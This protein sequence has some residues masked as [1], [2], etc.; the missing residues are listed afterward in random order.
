MIRILFCA[1]AALGS[2]ASPTLPDKSRSASP[3]APDISP[4]GKLVA[5]SY[6]GDLWLVDA[7][8]GVAQHLTMHEK[9]DFNPVFSPD[10]KWIAFSSNRHGQ[11]DVFVVPVKGGRPKRLTY[12]SADDHV[13]GWSPDGKH[14]LF[15]RAAARS[16][17]PHRALHRPARRRPGPAHQRLRGPRRRLS[18]PKGDRIAY[19]RGPGTWYRKGYRGS[20]NDDIWICDADGAQQSPHHHA[21]RPGQLPACGR[22]DG[23]SLYYVSDCPR[24]P[25]TSSSRARRRLAPADRQPVA[26]TQHKDDSVRRA[27]IGAQTARRSSTSAA[28]IS[29][30]ISLKEGKSRKLEDRGPRRRQDQPRTAQDLHQRR[31][32]VRLVARREAHRLRRARR[33]LSDAAQRRQG[34]TAHRSS[35]LRSRHRLG[36]RRQE[37]PLPLRPQR[38][39]R[40]L[41][42]RIRTTPT[43]PSSSQAHQLQGQAAHQHARSRVR[44]QLL[45]R[46]QPRRLPPRRQARHHEPR[47]QRREGRSST[48]GRSSITSGRPTASGSATPAWTAPSPAS[49]SS[50]PRPAP[51]AADPPRNVTRFA[52]YNGGVT[53]SKTG[54]KL[55]FISQPPGQRLQRLCPVAAES[56]PRQRLS[57]TSQRT[58]TGTTSICASSSRR[59]MNVNE[60]AISSDGTKIAFRAAVDDSD[61]LWVANADGGQVTR[62]TTGNLKPTQIQWSRSSPARSISAT[63]AATSA[64]PVGG[65]SRHRTARTVA[66]TAKM[67]VRQDD[68]FP[69][70]FDQS[71]RALNE[72]FYDAKF[73]GAD[74][75]DV[76]TS[77]ARS[78]STVRMK[79]DL[80][81]PISLMLGELNASHL[82]ITGN[83]GAPEQQTADLGLIFDRPLPRPGL[84]I[85][86]ILKRRPRRPARP[87]P[88]AGRP[89]PR[90]R[91]HE[92][93]ENV[94]VSQAAQRQGRRDRSSLHV[95]S[96]RRTR[97]QAPRRDSQARSRTQD[98]RAACTN[99]GSTDNADRGQRAEQAASSATSTSRAWT[100]PAWIASSAPST[101][102][103]ST[104]T[105]SS[106]TS[107]TTAAASRTIRC[108][109]TSP[110]RST[111][112]SRHRDGASGP[113][114]AIVRPQMDQA[115]HAA[116]QQSLLS[117][118]PRSSPRL[119]HLGPGQARRPADRR[120]RH[121]HAQ[122]AL[123][124][125]S[126]FRTP[127]I[128][129]HT[130]KGVNME[131]EG[132]I[133]DVLVEPHPDQLARGI[134][135][136]LDRAVEVLDAMTWPRGRKRGRPIA[137]SSAR[138]GRAEP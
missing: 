5:F 24:R 15:I 136:Q 11:Y 40:H 126:T 67:T 59:A 73:H 69:E 85:A 102:T 129:V 28:P 34:E 130:L 42:A 134:D 60:C 75:H 26:V 105:A 96:T 32:R 37:D 125:G 72:N 22:A 36:P 64:P 57:P 47:R 21:Q 138:A 80:Y 87:Q 23:K 65:R 29:G 70:M 122:I 82:G 56:P 117:A 91:R 3:A 111:P 35:R 88:Q 107:A 113:G 55:A 30:S 81:C 92:L 123:I 131:K 76:R 119:P 127:R 137:R 12:D 17:R 14:I 68:L 83:L 45:P 86:E 93:T 8:G 48:T 99:A 133:P 74:W 2:P 124:D 118:T 66:F 77:T 16:S 43:I 61:D 13:T 79:E 78:S 71:W 116:H 38:P 62:L 7:N 33:D 1:L 18:R 51:T 25:P 50:F 53:W 46:R 101:P 97:R 52:T 31:H 39:R 9:H 4:D 20:S 95:T 54:N 120:L 89:H 94:N 108:S 49:S 41:P 112:S 103:T 121:R 98:R 128:G 44:R 63:A 110:A 135:L 104:R 19:V 27:R 58:S 132:V 6:L 10:G 90:H 115:A 106:S 114:A 109:T 84:K 100:R